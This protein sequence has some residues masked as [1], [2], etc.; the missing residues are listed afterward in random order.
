MSASA[1]P[2]SPIPPGNYPVAVAFSSPGRIARWRPLVHWLLAIPHFFVLY[3]LNIV[4]GVL[5]FVAWILGVVTGR[6]PE[7]VQGLVV[8]YHRYAVRV[9][10]YVLF[11]REEYP[12]FAFDT[13]FTDPGTDPRTR[14]D[15][16]PA[17][18][19][20]N[21][22]TIFFRGLLIIPH[23]IVLFFLAIAC[24]SGVVP[25]R[26]HP[27]DVAVQRLRQPA[28]RRLPAVRVR[29]G[30]ARVSSA[31]AAGPSRAGSRAP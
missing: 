27:L 18:E 9:Q 17:I 14:F 30:A 24:G 2:P 1:P 19:G 21:R 6:I 23:A 15:V 3:I 16:V 13:D 25:G 28:D 31:G 10:T 20:R 5:V 11:L 12:P 7:G 26:L 22:L 8:A 29:V 4:A